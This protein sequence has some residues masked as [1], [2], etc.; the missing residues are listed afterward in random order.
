MLEMTLCMPPYALKNEKTPSPCQW[1]IDMKGVSTFILC[2]GAGTRL[3]PLTLSR[4][5]PAICFGGRY[6]LIDIPIS[7]AFNSG[8]EKIYL[9]TQ[10]LSTSLHRHILKTYRM[11]ARQGNSIEILT[12]EQKPGKEAWYQGTADAIRQNR[13][14][15]EECDSEFI[16]ILS[17]DQVYQM[18]F[19]SMV[20]LAKESDADLV[21]AALPVSP[22]DTSEMGILQVSDDFLIQ[23]FVE[24]PQTEL[25]TLKSALNL[26]CWKGK[27]SSWL[28]SMG[29]YL[30]KK[31]ALL[32][33]LDEDP[34]EDFGKHLIPT[35]ILKG[36]ARAYLHPSY[37]EDVGTID[38]FYKANMALTLPSPPFDIFN[39]SFNFCS[40]PEALPPSKIANCLIQHSLIAEGSD[41]E[42]SSITHSIIGPRMLIG[43]GTAI[44]DSYLFGNKA[45]PLPSTDLHENSAFAIG[46]HCTIKKALIDKQ[47][48]IGHHVKLI[49]KAGLQTYQK[50]SIYIRDGIIVVARGAH[51]PD[52]FEL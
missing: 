2:G 48:K 3:L 1:R 21:I 41:I 7:N 32:K 30:F 29:I 34:R 52:Y 51:I 10:F 37:W 27:K 31:K 19:A 6:R 22:E 50:G 14:Y 49:N 39:N 26:S 25:D 40:Y 23:R 45:Y 42:A 33:L 16:L 8:C 4:C 43:K 18:N 5:K 44:E 13:E 17:G 38:R 15:L 20:E 36:G 35:Q 11:D 46:A 9:L 28:G 12:A 47:V 24:K